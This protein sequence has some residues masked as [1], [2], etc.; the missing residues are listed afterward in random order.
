MRVAVRGV[1]VA[2]TVMVAMGYSMWVAMWTVTMWTVAMRASH[3][4]ATSMWI[5]VL[6]EEETSDR[7]RTF[8][9]SW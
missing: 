2:M 9:M 3:M 8:H 6:P 4:R 5:A 7:S 1:W